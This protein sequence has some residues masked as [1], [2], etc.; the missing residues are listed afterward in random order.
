MC[1]FGCVRRGSLLCG[2]ERENLWGGGG[3]TC[4]SLGWGIIHLWQPL[5]ERRRTRRQSWWRWFESRCRPSMGA[6]SHRSRRV[7]VAACAATGVWCHDVYFL[8]GAGRL[9]DAKIDETS[10]RSA[11]T[12]GGVGCCRGGWFQRCPLESSTCRGPKSRSPRVANPCTGRLKTTALAIAPSMSLANILALP[13]GGGVFPGRGRTCGCVWG[14]G[15]CY[16][17][18]EDLH[19]STGRLLGKRGRR[20]RR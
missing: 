13:L 1:V 5:S 6:T 12:G 10:T 18:E 11:G 7:P 19:G 8:F 2:Q 20:A 16:I 15:G 17:K 9:L 14:G 4:R 3:T